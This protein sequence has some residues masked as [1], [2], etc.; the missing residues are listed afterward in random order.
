MSFSL[1]ANVVLRVAAMLLPYQRRTYRSIG[2]RTDHIDGDRRR[3]FDN[4]CHDC[5]CR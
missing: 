3:L 2:V 1:A 5:D 4:P